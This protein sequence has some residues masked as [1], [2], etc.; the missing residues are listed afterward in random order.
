MEKKQYNIKHSIGGKEMQVTRKCRICGKTKTGGV[1]KF[2]KVK[3]VLKDRSL[4]S[5]VR[6]RLKSVKS[7]AYICSS[8]KNVLWKLEGALT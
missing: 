4:G 1:G 2:T 5:K 3:N 6:L 7:D 8:C